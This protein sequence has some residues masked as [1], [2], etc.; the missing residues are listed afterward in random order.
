MKLL[1]VVTA[2]GID[3]TIESV[4]WWTL[5]YFLI[6]HVFL[7]LVGEMTRTLIKAGIK[8]IWNFF[9]GLFKTV[10]KKEYKMHYQ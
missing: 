2:L 9:C 6:V 5:L 4:L 8:F 7:G 10:P 3:T 1:E